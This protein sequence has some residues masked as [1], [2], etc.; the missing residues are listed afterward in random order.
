M[1]DVFAYDK[2]NGQGEIPHSVFLRTVRIT[3]LDPRERTPERLM[4]SAWNDC[5]RR[6]TGA[7][8]SRN[9]IATRRRPAR[10]SRQQCRRA[11]ELTTPRQPD[12]LLRSEHPDM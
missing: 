4:M 12:R 1:I 3:N 10:G 5:S 8:R 9:A 2:Q 7:I 6:G 11:E